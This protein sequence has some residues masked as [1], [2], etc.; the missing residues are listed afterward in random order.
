MTFEEFLQK[1]SYGQKIH[2]SKEAKSIAIK[3]FVNIANVI[4]R[5]T[6][7]IIIIESR[8]GHVRFSMLRVL[9]FT[10]IYTEKK[11]FFEHNCFST[12]T[13]YLTYER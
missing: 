8:Y 11:I 9:R 4:W 3:L 12:G 6:E 7:R 2:F 1:C 5:P 13:R 10:C